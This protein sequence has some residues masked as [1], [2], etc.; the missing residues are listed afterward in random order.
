L[1]PDVKLRVLPAQSVELLEAVGVPGIPL[2][3][4]LTVPAALAHPFTVW[5][6]EY[7]PVARVVA[8]TM[9]GFCKFEVKV[10]GPVQL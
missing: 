3:V 5:V 2:I 10:F 7:I 6:T 4:T 9:V 1:G 8:P